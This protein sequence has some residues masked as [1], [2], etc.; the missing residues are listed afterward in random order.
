MTAPILLFVYN[1]ASHTRQTLD[2]LSKNILSK[3]SLLYIYS[4]GAKNKKDEKSVEAVRKI[5][6][7]YDSFFKKVIIIEHKNN[8]GLANSIINGVSETINRHKKVIVLED[9][10]LTHQ[11]FLT[12]MNQMLNV[13]ESISKIWSISGFNFSKD[14]LQVPTNYLYDIYFSVRP[15]SWGWATWIDRW[16]KVD[17]EV[18]DYHKFK[19]NIRLKKEFN[20]GGDD[21]SHMLNMQMSGDID[22]WAIRFSYSAFKNESY[23]VYPINSFIKNI[24]Q[25]GSGQH[26]NNKNEFKN[27]LNFKIERNLKITKDIVINKDIKNKFKQIYRITFFDKL[28]GT[29]KRKIKKHF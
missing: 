2:C 25:D 17:W 14:K 28:K 3:E 16:N 24:G 6:K 18:K 26:S 19:K 23:S 20:L 15:C 22:S 7:E 27:N 10:L 5:I 4:D 11:F 29:I 13:Y 8:Q 12:Y 21:L 1:R 9:D